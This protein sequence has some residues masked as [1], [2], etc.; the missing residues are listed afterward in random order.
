MTYYYIR[1]PFPPR[2]EKAENCGG[3]PAPRK[4]IGTAIEMARRRVEAFGS[5]KPQAFFSYLVFSMLSRSCFRSRGAAAII[6]VRG[7]DTVICTLRVLVSSLGRFD[8]AHISSKHGGFF[9]SKKKISPSGRLLGEGGTRNE[10]HQVILNQ[11]SE[12]GAWIGII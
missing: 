11:Y 10:H 6:N 9:C 4:S 12:V 7:C 8:P 1:G 2:D 3:R 5:V